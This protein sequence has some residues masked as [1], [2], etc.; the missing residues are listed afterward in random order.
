[1][2]TVPSA[3]TTQAGVVAL[4]QES[5]TESGSIALLVVAVS[6][7]TTLRDC[8]VFQAPV[9]VSGETVGIAVGGVTVGV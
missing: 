5:E 2:V 6:L 1:M 7:V 8:G 9:E 4:V 3:F